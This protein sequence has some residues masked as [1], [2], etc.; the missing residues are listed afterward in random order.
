MLVNVYGL[1]V[2]F[3]QQSTDKLALRTKGEQIAFFTTNSTLIGQSKEIPLTASYVDVGSRLPFATME[4]YNY[5]WYMLEGNYYFY[6]VTGVDF[7]VV[8]YEGGKQNTVRFFIELDRL[9]TKLYDVIPQSSLVNRKIFGDVLPVENVLETP[10]LNQKY[11]VVERGNITRSDGFGNGFWHIIASEQLSKTAGNEPDLIFNYND[12]YN[13]IYYYIIPQVNEWS[14]VLNG[15]TYPGVTLELFLQAM[16]ADD[17]LSNKILGIYYDPLDSQTLTYSGVVAGVPTFTVVGPYQS[18][19]AHW[20]SAAD[21]IMGNPNR[22]VLA[23]SVINYNLVD[24]PYTMQLPSFVRPPDNKLECYPFKQYELVYK[25]EV[26]QTLYPQNTPNLR[27]LRYRFI[28]SVSPTQACCIQNVDNDYNQLYVS[29]SLYETSILTDEYMQYLRSQKNSLLTTNLLTAGGAALAIGVAALTGGVGALIATGLAGGAAVFGGSLSQIAKL[30]DVEANST[31]DVTTAQTLVN[32]LD[33]YTHIPFVVVKS[34]SDDD[35]SRLSD[36]FL[37]FGYAYEQFIVPNFFEHSNY[38]Y[39]VIGDL[40]LSNA[41]EWT[42]SYFK[43]QFARGV[44]LW[45]D[46]ETMYDYTA[47]NSEA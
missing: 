6:Y 22:R 26:I 47:I 41:D 23:Y 43:A 32:D 17:T 9:Q 37:R 46:P 4:K 24:R 19:T 18:T 1:T 31:V 20:A 40:I 38:D 21:P 5:M 7:G 10:E 14:F 3:T 8:Q 42:S 33:M 11:K 15:T 13:G 12:V 45:H 2:P 27:E 28:P 39:F 36:Y 44:R 30:S 25:N 35:Y 29:N 16:L 34:V